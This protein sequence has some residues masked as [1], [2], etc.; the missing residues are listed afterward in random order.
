MSDQEPARPDL[1]EL[2]YPYAL[3]AVAEIER[4]HIDDR[5]RGADAAT[6]AEFSALV[7]GVRET[8]AVLSALDSRRPPAHLEYAVLRAI[9]AAMS[10]AVR[11]VNLSVGAVERPAAGA[12]PS[13]AVAA[14]VRL[15]GQ[16]GG[17]T[18]PPGSMSGRPPDAVVPATTASC[19]R[20]GGRRDL[21]RRLG[22]AR[23]RQRRDVPAASSGTARPP[24][25]QRPGS[26]KLFPIAAAALAVLAG[27]G[28][29]ILLQ[30]R[31]PG[32]PA[33]LRADTVLDQPDVKGSAAEL[34]AGGT[35]TVTS[36]A[37]LGAATV[38]FA[39]LPEPPRGHCYQ[40][41]LLGADGT[42]RSVGVME[43]APTPGSNVVLRT[44]TGDALAVTIEP[45]HGSAQPT[46]TP[47]V[48][49]P[50]A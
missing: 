10:A 37:R 39:A 24:R 29:A 36:S 40:M 5:V 41:W 14:D 18:R 50:L 27:I 38:S 31:E 49:I 22:G 32:P 19:V 23:W 13:G 34:P 8:M 2:A 28:A 9:D 26:S 16:A 43:H 25:A 11:T 33:A 44:G 45:G 46:G 15:T 42:P 3:D 30:Q 35:L 17:G 48:R 7:R 47:L 21:A 1:L 20:A 6:A 12:G 4:R